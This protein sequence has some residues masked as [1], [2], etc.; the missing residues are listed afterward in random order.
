MWYRG[1]LRLLFGIEIFLG[2]IEILRSVV[3]DRD[4][5]LPAMKPGV[6]LGLDILYIGGRKRSRH[7]KEDRKIS[8]PKTRHLD[9]N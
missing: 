4:R 8:I 7:R 2:G 6:F 5:P 9:A 3:Q 1:G